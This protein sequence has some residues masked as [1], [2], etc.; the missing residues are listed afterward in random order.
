[1]YTSTTKLSHRQTHSTYPAPLCSDQR[2]LKG[3]PLPMHGPPLG[4]VVYLLLDAFFFPGLPPQWEWRELPSSLSCSQ[5]DT[6]WPR[7]KGPQKGSVDCSWALSLSDQYTHIQRHTGTVHMSHTLSSAWPINANI[8][9]HC[10]HRQ[11]DSMWK[12]A[13]FPT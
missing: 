10:L 4:L 6:Q 11:V 7:T 8:Q 13:D 2:R 3:F 12:L 9:L 1:M 5:S